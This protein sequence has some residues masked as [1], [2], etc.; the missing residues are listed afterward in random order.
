MTDVG[1]GAGVGVTTGIGA[2]SATSA[3]VSVRLPHDAK[4]NAK[5]TAANPIITNLIKTTI[6]FVPHD[7]E[8]RR[9]SFALSVTLRDSNFA[10]AAA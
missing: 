2:V 7:V 6:Y 3:L 8:S 10:A 1:E 5:T 9:I 4:P